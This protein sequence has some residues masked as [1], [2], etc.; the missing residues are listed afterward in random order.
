MVKNGIMSNNLKFSI[1]WW[2]KRLQAYE[3]FKNLLNENNLIF[4]P[5]LDW[6]LT[7]FINKMLI[8]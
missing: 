6:Y 5:K 8:L 4:E 2:K 1:K 3:F 7:R